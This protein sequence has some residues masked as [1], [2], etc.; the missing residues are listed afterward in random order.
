M[1]RDLGIEERAPAG[2]HRR[3]AAAGPAGGRR[4]RAN[5]AAPARQR[6]GRRRREAG[7]RAATASDAEARRSRATASTGG[8][9]DGH[10]RV[11]DDGPRHLAL[12]DLPAGPL[13]GRDRRRVPGRAVRRDPHRP[14]RQ[15]LQRP[16]RGR[17]HLAS[18]LEAVPGALAG[19]ALVYFVG[20]RQGNEA[21]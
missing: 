21:A 14:H 1:V 6:P 10:A 3:D 2:E 15:R 11:G 9:A 7:R 5:G 17:H 12:H 16:R 18:A 4:A 8:L 13:L 19:I 20:V